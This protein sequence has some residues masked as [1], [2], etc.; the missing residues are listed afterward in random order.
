ME[1]NIN[2]LSA[3]YPLTELQR[4]YVIGRDEE[5]IATKVIYELKV[6]TADIVRI[7]KA[8]DKTIISQPVL[9]S[10]LS[11]KFCLKFR[12]RTEHY[13][14]KVTDM[15]DVPEKEQK[16][17]LDREFEKCKLRVWDGNNGYPFYISAVKLS[18]CDTR[19]ILD[20][21]MLIFDGMSIKLFVDKVQYFYENPEEEPVCDYSFFNYCL[22]REKLPETK[23]YKKAKDFWLNKNTMLSQAPD[24]SHYNSDMTGKN[25]V[26]DR[27]SLFLEEREWSRIKN[28]ILTNNI[29][30][31]VLM[32]A[33]YAKMLGIYS[34]LSRFTVNVPIANRKSVSSCTIGDFTSVLLVDINIEQADM[35]QLSEHIQKQIIIALKNRKFDGIEVMREISGRD[36]AES[37]RFPVVFTPMLYDDF[38]I[39]YNSPFGVI[40]RGCSQTTNVLLDCQIYEYQN[41]LYINFD[42]RRNSFDKEIIRRMFSMMCGDIRSFSDESSFTDKGFIGKI[43]ESDEKEILRY[44]DTGCDIP[45]CNL[46]ELLVSG[47]E[48]NREKVA[49][50][51]RDETITYGELWEKSEQVCSYILSHDVGRGDTVAVIG[52]RNIATIINIIGVVKSGAVYVPV[53]VV[54]PENRRD[55]IIRK[56]QCKL[57]IDDNTDFSAY[58]IV[59][60]STVKYYPDDTAYIIFTSGSTG[61]P[62]GVSIKHSAVVNTILDI[63]RRYNITEDDVLACVS[64]IG[65]DLSVYDIF[66]SLIAGAELALVPDVYNVEEMVSILSDRGVT[67][68][69][70]VPAVFRLIVDFL[71]RYDDKDGSDSYYG[72]YFS[73]KEQEMNY[74]LPLRL[75][76]LSGDWISKNIVAKAMKMFPDCRMVSL[77]GATEASIWSVFYNIDSI[78]DEWASIPY[79]YPLGNQT[80]YIIDSNEKIVPV[81]AKGEICIGGAGVA[82]GYCNDIQKTNAQFCENS[83]LGRIYHTGD[84]GCMSSEGYIILFGRRDNQVKINGFR[85]ELG[86]IENAIKKLSYV[87]NAV[88]VVRQSDNGAKSICVYVSLYSP[89]DENKIRNDSADNLPHYMIPSRVVILD[90]FP[91]TSNGKIDR[92]ALPE[93]YES[94][95]V[96]EDAE[97]ELETRISE[98]WKKYL[99]TDDIN[100]NGQF[101][102]LGG[103]SLAMISIVNDIKEQFGVDI[104]FRKFMILGTV[105]NIAVYIKENAENYSDSEKVIYKAVQ[106]SN[107]EKYSNFPLTDIQMSYFIGRNSGIRL[108]NVSTHAYYEIENDF[109][110]PRLSNALNKVIRDNPMLRV[111]ISPDGT[112]RILEKTRDYII[113]EE[114]I[115]GFSAEEQEKILLNA[116]EEHS[117]KVIDVSTF[118]LFEFRAFRL[119]DNKVRL[120]VGFDLLIADGISMRIFTKELLQYYYSETATSKN[121]NFNFHDY[122]LSLNEMKNS[123]YYAESEKYWNEQADTFAGAPS[124]PMKTSVSDIKKPLFSR[125]RHNISSEKWSAVKEILLSYGITPSVFLMTVYGRILAYYSS[126]ETVT[127]NV[128][129]FTRFP[130]N[131]SVNDMIGDF[132][133]VMLVDVTENGKFCDVCRNIQERIAENLEHKAYDGV[134]VIRSISRKNN[135][136]GELLFP[137]VFTGMIFENQDSMNIDDVGDIVYS[138][139]QTSQVYLDC[140]VMSD[141]NGISITWDYVSQLF[142]TELIE[143]IFSEFIDIIENTALTLDGNITSH[144]NS[145][146][147]D[148]IE[149]YNSTDMEYYVPTLIEAFE[150]TAKAMPDKTAITAGNESCTYAEL[151]EKA[152]R[153]A[154]GLEE[155]GIRKNSTVAVY[156]YRNIDTVASILAV[157]KCGATYVPISPDIPEERKKFI[158][159]NS[160]ADFEIT[161]E[162]ISLLSEYRVSG[163]KH[164][165]PAL[166]D[167]AYIIY[168]SGSTGQPKGVVMTH[169]GAMNTIVDINRRFKVSSG[170]VLLGVSS[171]TFDLSVYDI[172]GAFL[173]GAELVLAQNSKNVSELSSLLTDHSVTVWNSVPAIFSLMMSE[174]SD[175]TENYFDMTSENINITLEDTYSLRLVMLSGDY[176]PTD[177]PDRI[178]DK[179]SNAE[180]ISLGGATEGG[181]W[182][183]FY[184]V[185]KV[186]ENWN[187]IPYGY[188]LSN[189]Q[190]YIIGKDNNIC[191]PMV[192]GEIAI[193]GKSLSLG[194]CGDSEKTQSAFIEHPELGRIYKT[195][196]MGIMHSEGY[197]E[198]RGRRDNQVKING[199]RIEL[200]EIESSLLKMKNIESSVAVVS[201][202]K[203]IAFY[204]SAEPVSDDDIRTF[205]SEYIPAYMIPTVIKHIDRLPVTANG[206]IDRKKLVC[207]DLLS[208]ERT[209][210]SPRTENEK[211]LYNY[212]SDA[213]G[214]SSF[215]ITDSFFELGGDSIKGINMYNKLSEEYEMELNLI[216]RYQTVEQLAKHIKK[217]NNIYFNERMEKFRKEYYSVS[218]DNSAEHVDMLYKKY[219]EDIFCDTDKTADPVSICP[220]KV[221][222]TGASGY[223]GAYIAEKVLRDTEAEI[224]LTARGNN[225]EKKLAENLE[226][227][228]GNGFVEKFRHRLHFIKSEL[229][230]SELGMDNY[231]YTKLANEI[232]IVFNCA[233][234][235]QHFGKYEDFSE[236]NVTSVKNLIQF[237]KT[238]IEKKLCH[239]STT[240]ISENISAGD[241]ILFTENTYAD[242]E[243]SEEYYVQTKKEAEDLILQCRK[244]GIR[245]DIYRIGTVLFDSHNGH[246]QKNIA[247]NSFYLIMQSFFN[248]GAMPD[249]DASILDFSFVDECADAVVRL[250]LTE[251]CAGGTYHIYNPN[252][253]SMRDFYEKLRD[254]GMEEEMDIMEFDE[255]F[256][257]VYDKYKDENF[258]QDIDTLLLHSG[259]YIST[260]SGIC[261]VVNDKTCSILNKLGFRWSDVTEKHISDMLDYGKKI[262]FFKM[263]K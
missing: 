48:R 43:L 255:F 216:F 45:V 38:S 98:L 232:E 63:N 88:A 244:E 178:K 175:S 73:G 259:T 203:I 18:D 41:G 209:I 262:N 118:P 228:F 72:D 25:A 133:S 165:Y 142:E 258:R 77:G 81:G 106:C 218:D 113:P 150:K 109:D 80:V 160:H 221:M 56:S 39:S 166:N 62:K 229:S 155:T 44:N 257:F 4:S 16:K 76:M 33:V 8:I 234:K 1:K 13:H 5:E 120:L 230:F 7:E 132:T 149:M 226:F 79:G 27:C 66:G 237:C 163:K 159:E 195:G 225:Y 196:D 21:D 187:T 34:G 96:C 227:Y 252:K 70:S 105:R 162:N 11:D 239:L 148:M 51:C 57:V 90:D 101:I 146:E 144:L 183:I 31:Y 19:F 192:E 254:S 40:V 99:R 65:F 164:S 2:F 238:G 91:L 17:F 127:L 177:L 194:Y 138:V 69:N 35:K 141:S 23:N 89:A 119:S 147:R 184:P 139:S 15:T 20:F 135:R 215:S 134:S 71:G 9:N 129:T 6:P 94:N 92:N 29:Q 250:A 172:F 136:N 82:E 153:I 220:K 224:Y 222:I 161:K 42:Y 210:I 126:A 55:A 211:V 243:F 3:E 83:R 169:G 52:K 117:H 179:Y 121:E 242:T 246:F 110:I 86:E 200:G 123:P 176:I 207:M 204:T 206:K 158:L 100:V 10:S 156:E 78:K 185:G 95:I 85:V 108:G 189:Q 124:L 173:A 197:V 37:S 111:V 115:S 130:F 112:Q 208:D 26:F 50:S 212:F 168:T 152:E 231:E 180:I 235:V 30:P 236:S 205:V 74:I 157:L 102:E 241:G 12:D 263:V 104:S 128:T 199:Y 182:S 54:Q 170:D 253:L 245:A 191:P 60:S 103:D 217:R 261:A 193:G 201:D 125:C 68:W 188:P 36:D 93:P 84:Y 151:N 251:E 213:L 219:L 174:K 59:N 64:S 214:I 114:D 154:S 249:I 248:L 28:N 122:I 202:N 61:E 247:S 171:F 240:R 190:I 107:D 47:F 260:D 46:M 233:G 137:Y 131:P 256:D 198:F 32:L 186:E 167:T 143:K 14:I 67:V 58:S 53:D 87:K 97:N 145:K 181:I 140:Q 22:E 116:R 223:I 24:I 49:V 75:V